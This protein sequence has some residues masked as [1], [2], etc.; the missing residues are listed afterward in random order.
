MVLLS[1]LTL[2]ELAGLAVGVNNPP[3]A[4]DPLQVKTRSG[5][6]LGILDHCSGEPRPRRR[7]KF[8]HDGTV[9]S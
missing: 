3:T 6:M 7:A 8:A 9:G 2:P 1:S 5:Q 4:L